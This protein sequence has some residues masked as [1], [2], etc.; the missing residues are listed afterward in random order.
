MSLT[1]SLTSISYLSRDLSSVVLPARQSIN[2]LPYLSLTVGLQDAC[3][4]AVSWPS[5][6]SCLVMSMVVSKGQTCDEFGG[7]EFGVMSFDR[8]VI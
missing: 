8:N 2:K 7:Q 5:I 6:S 3:V 1:K 4:V